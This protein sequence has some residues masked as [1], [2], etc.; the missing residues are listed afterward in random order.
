MTHAGLSL[1]GVWFNPH[2]FSAR[3]SILSLAATSGFC[4]CDG[5]LL[6]VQLDDLRGR[7]PGLPLGLLF[8][9]RRRPLPVLHRV[10]Y[11]ASSRP[12]LLALVMLAGIQLAVP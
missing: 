4:A 12:T 7:G 9:R 11:T 5:D 6:G 10:R 2:A 1:G 8:R 3:S